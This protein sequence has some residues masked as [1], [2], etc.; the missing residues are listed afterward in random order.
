MVF[1]KMNEYYK[2]G[3]EELIKNKSMNVQEAYDYMKKKIHVPKGFYVIDGG[4]Y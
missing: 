3:I 4:P 2:N 1:G